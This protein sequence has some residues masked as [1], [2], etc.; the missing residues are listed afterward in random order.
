MPLEQTVLGYIKINNNNTANDVDDENT[1]ISISPNYDANAS[2]GNGGNRNVLNLT[3]DTQEIESNH[4][5]KK[6]RK[7]GIRMLT[8]IMFW[9]LDNMLKN[10]VDHEAL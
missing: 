8:D 5:G 6:N 10:L 9:V 4:I 1:V 3:G 2:N 7:K